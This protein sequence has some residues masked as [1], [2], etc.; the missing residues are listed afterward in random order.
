M[1]R[2]EWEYA[3]K[4][5]E[6]VPTKPAPATAPVVEVPVEAAVPPAVVVQAP[7]EKSMLQKLRDQLSSLE[8]EVEGALK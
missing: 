4:H 5:G 3:K 2:W 8:A 6:T 7:P 1:N